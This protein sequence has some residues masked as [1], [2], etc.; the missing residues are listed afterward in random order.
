MFILALG[1][2]LALQQS[3]PPNQANQAPPRSLRAWYQDYQLGLDAFNKQDWANAIKSFEA[4]RQ[5]R[6]PTS[7][8]KTFATGN[9]SVDYIPDYYLG[10]A[11]F[12]LKQ[13]AQAGDAFNRLKQLNSVTQKDKEYAT[14]NDT[15]T[16]AGRALFDQ[17][18]ADANA[19]LT[20]GKTREA[21]AKLMEAT[22]NA[23][24]DAKRLSELKD[25]V[26]RATTA[27][28][29]P[30]ANNLPATT[31]PPAGNPPTTNNPPAGNPPAGN[32][33]PPAGN[34][35]PPAGNANPPAGGNQPTGTTNPP[36]GGTNPPGGGRSNPPRNQ[37]QSNPPSA[38]NDQVRFEISVVDAFFTGQYEQARDAVAERMTG[39]G[40]TAR[41]KLFS[42]CSEA[43]LVLTG[44]ADPATLTTARQRYADAMGSYTLDKDLQFISPKILSLLQAK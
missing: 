39:P 20:A 13:Y 26:G 29:N 11:Y 30:P 10:I 16:K 44:R 15:A 1:L 32:A 6:A 8:R 19:L 18:E 9:T 40:A 27:A 42:A 12:N 24:A 25:R 41:M 34:A 3:A 23:Y 5:S 31:N 22:R 37:Q 33:N 2:I 28:N 35:N 17:Q 21:D 43:A 4:A 36:A 14:F 38:T 7:V